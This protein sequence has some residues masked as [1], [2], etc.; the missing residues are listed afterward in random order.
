M[1]KSNKNKEKD[2]TLMQS[3]S[4]MPHSTQHPFLIHIEILKKGK[5]KTTKEKMAKIPIKIAAN[6]NKSRSNATSFENKGI[7]HFD[8]NIESVLE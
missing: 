4:A 2:T 3:S 7:S 6:G 1:T 5:L 8:N